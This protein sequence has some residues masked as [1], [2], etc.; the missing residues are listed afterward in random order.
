MS[1]LQKYHV[2]VRVLLIAKQSQFSNYYFELRD[3]ISR[4]N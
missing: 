1:I 3:Y 4:I 2:E